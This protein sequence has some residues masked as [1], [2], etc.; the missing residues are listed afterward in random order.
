MFPFPGR[1]FLGNVPSQG[2]AVW[3]TYLL[4][5]KYISGHSSGS[6]RPGPTWARPQSR[7][8]RGPEKGPPT[9]ERK[10]PGGTDDFAYFAMA[11]CNLRIFDILCIR[12][13]ILM[14]RHCLLCFS[15]SYYILFNIFI[16]LL[17][18]HV[19]GVLVFPFNFTL[20]GTLHIFAP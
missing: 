20:R 7:D 17:I 12:L 14:R 13:G 11:L 18:S 15:V 9:A 2:K 16:T 1:V 10:F 5:R 6:D 4:R 19:S 3:L 8:L